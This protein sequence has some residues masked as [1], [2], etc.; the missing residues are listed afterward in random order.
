MSRHNGFEIFLDP[1]T[2][3]LEF[4]WANGAK[5]SNIYSAIQLGDILL[6]TVDAEQHEAQSS[7]LREV[8]PE[9]GQGVEW[10]I[11]HRS[12]GKPVLTQIITAYENTSFCFIRLEVAGVTAEETLSTNYKNR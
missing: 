9:Y 2:G 10:I 5:I 6:R 11:N 3:I 4:Q 8:H 7:S 12:S 1:K